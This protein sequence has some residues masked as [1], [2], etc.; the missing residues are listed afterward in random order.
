MSYIVRAFMD[1][2]GAVSVCRINNYF[3]R[4][5]IG[6]LQGMDTYFFRLSVVTKL[7]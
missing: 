5:E 3:N 4:D 6:K 7:T 2:S 1:L